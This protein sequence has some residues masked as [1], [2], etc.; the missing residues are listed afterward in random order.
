MGAP[1]D[2]TADQIKE[3]KE[4]MTIEPKDVGKVEDILGIIPTTT[5]PEEKKEI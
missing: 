5:M 4:T 1:Q 3:A 2:D